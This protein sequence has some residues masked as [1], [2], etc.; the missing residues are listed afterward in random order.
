MTVDQA[1][2]IFDVLFEKRDSLIDKVKTAANAT[3]VRSG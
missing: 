2:I 3:A 1:K